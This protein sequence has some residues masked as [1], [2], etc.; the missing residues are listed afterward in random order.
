MRRILLIIGVL[1][2]AAQPS[3]AEQMILKNGHVLDG[4]PVGR[5]GDWVTIEVNGVNNTW[6]MDEI[7]YMGPA[8]R[9]MRAAPAEQPVPAQT[10][11]VTPA[12]IRITPQAPIEPTTVDV[13]E[14]APS[15]APAEEIQAPI[16]SDS[17]EDNSIPVADVPAEQATDVAAAAVESAT[18]PVEE[19][20]VSEPAPVEAIPAVEEVQEQPAPAI[21]AP[22]VETPAAPAA[23]PVVSAPAVPSN[24]PPPE[25]P[26]ET[27]ASSDEATESQPG[28]P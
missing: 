3:P 27:A 11:S 16:T 4:N 23:D 8:I 1:M 7:T 22:T 18:Q 17:K 14:A 2:L 28:T 26:A 9:N 12:E 24:D 19:P 21:E 13:P 6:N 20:I 15:S 25:A 10:I 5:N